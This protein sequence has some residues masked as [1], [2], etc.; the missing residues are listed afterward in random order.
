MFLQPSIPHTFPA[1]HSNCIPRPLFQ[2]YS[3]LSLPIMFPA[4]PATRT[5][6]ILVQV[7]CQRSRPN[8]PTASLSR[9]IA[10]IRFQI[11]PPALQFKCTPSFTLPIHPTAFSSTP[12]LSCK[13]FTIVPIQTPPHLYL[14]TAAPAFFQTQSHPSLSN[15][16]P[17]VYFKCITSFLFQSH[18]HHYT[19]ITFP[20][21][22]SNCIPN[23]HF[24]IPPQPHLSN[25]CIAFYFK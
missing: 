7:H 24:Q 25:T 14:P 19:P 1:S 23:Q 2:I 12:S 16:C 17:A 3:Q 13:Y 20:A 11:P 8:T 10:S 15:T 4:F 21:L 9:Y 5:H 6:I 22:S 18:S